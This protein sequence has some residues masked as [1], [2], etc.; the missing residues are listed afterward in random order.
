M[1]DA[2]TLNAYMHH[3]TATGIPM[4][5]HPLLD[6]WSVGMEPNHC[7]PYSHMHHAYQASHAEVLR[8]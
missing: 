6:V 8:S 2:A 4:L 1:G 7:F 5:H 3:I